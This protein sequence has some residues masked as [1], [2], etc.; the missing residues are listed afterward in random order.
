MSGR[1]RGWGAVGGGGGGPNRGNHSETERERRDMRP[2]GSQ[3]RGTALN[4]LWGVEGIEPDGSVTC[5]RF[6]RSVKL[7][8]VPGVVIASWVLHAGHRCWT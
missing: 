7:E 4:D 8:T 1:G 3:K 2:K 5:S 6:F